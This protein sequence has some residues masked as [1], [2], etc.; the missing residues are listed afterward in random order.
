MT[1]R[2]WRARSSSAER[3]PRWDEPLSAIQNTRRAERYGSWF[4]T[5]STSRP[6]AALPVFGSQR[7]KTTARSTSQAAR[8]CRT[9]APLV[10]VFDTHGLVRSDQQTWVA[11][12]TDLD[13]G[14]FIRAE[15]ILVRPQ[16]LALP[17]A[18]VQIEHGT[19]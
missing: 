16:W 2:G 17:P 9:P 6:K 10:L 8:Y 7:P 13:A 5:S 11:P 18:G 15:H 3:S 14:L 12:T 4:M 1:M 19:G